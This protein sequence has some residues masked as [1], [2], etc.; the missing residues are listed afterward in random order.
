M[1]NKTSRR[2]ERGFTLI[3]MIMVIALIAAIAAVVTGKII[4]NRNRANYK[5][6]ETQLKNLAMNVDQYQS[7]VGELP[8]SLDQLSRS[9]AEGWL[10]P[11]AEAKDLKDPWNNAIEYR[12]PGESEAPFALVSL[13]VDGKPG[14]EGVDKDLVV[15]P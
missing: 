9:D 8:D 11:Y 15:S 10:G 2:G 4:Q 13:G 3:E 12:K 14:G 7:D 1:H 5:L 6:A